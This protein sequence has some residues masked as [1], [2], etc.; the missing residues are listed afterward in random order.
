MQGTEGGT[1]LQPVSSAATG[2]CPV[3]S[4]C[5]SASQHHFRR[6]W[7]LS[8]HASV[9]PTSTWALEVLAARASS[10]PAS[11]CSQLTLMPTPVKPR[12]SYTKSVSCQV[13]ARPDGHTTMLPAGFSP[14]PLTQ[15][16]LPCL[17]PCS[18]F[19]SYP[20]D[21]PLYTHL[22]FNL[23]TYNLTKSFDLPN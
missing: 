4:S 2:T 1:L 23:Y 14:S 9:L 12:L 19:P 6:N 17:S 16:Q 11:C 15:Q 10:Q 3:P 7:S 8:L 18:P 22:W 21:F 5:C 13:A 20:L